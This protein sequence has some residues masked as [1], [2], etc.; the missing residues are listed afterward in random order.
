MYGSLTFLPPSNFAVLD[1]W[2]FFQYCLQIAEKCTN[3][4][5]WSALST[6]AFSSYIRPRLL[7]VKSYAYEEKCE[8]WRQ[9]GFAYTICLSQTLV[10]D[11]SHLVMLVE[12]LDGSLT[13]SWFNMEHFKVLQLCDVFRFKRSY[14]LPMLQA[15]LRYKYYRRPLCLMSRT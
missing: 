13:F 5:T 6:F 3:C 8:Q 14:V 12:L 15:S 7:W 2:Y 4:S 10:S 9:Q 11:E 1:G